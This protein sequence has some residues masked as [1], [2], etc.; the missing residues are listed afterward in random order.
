MT[1]TGDFIRQLQKKSQSKSDFD[2]KFLVVAV[3]VFFLVFFAY[4]A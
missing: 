2:S 4:L 3:G 1:K